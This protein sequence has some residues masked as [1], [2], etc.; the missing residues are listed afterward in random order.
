M[1]VVCKDNEGFQDQLTVGEFYRVE[2]G[3]N[4]YQV[5]NDKGAIRW[6]GVR[7]FNLVPGAMV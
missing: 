7:F 6:Y 5:L 4:S 3:I 2:I 1:L